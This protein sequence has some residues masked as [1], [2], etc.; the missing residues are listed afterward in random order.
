MLKSFVITVS[1][2]IDNSKDAKQVG[3]DNKMNKTK[4]TGLIILCLSIVLSSCSPSKTI[5]Q[6]TG[7]K[8]LE[9]TIEAQT[10]AKVDVD[11][12]DGEVTIK[13]EDGQ[14][15]Y[16]AGGSAVLPSNFPKELIITSDAKIIIASTSG[17]N[18]SVTY[19]TNS[20]QNE[21]FDKYISDLT[22]LGWTKE[23][24]FD[25]G[26]GKMLNFA[27]E[28]T[29]VTITIGENNTKDQSEKTAVNIILTT[30]EN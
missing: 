5:G 25:A 3:G 6:K 15:Q 13:S 22:G 16:S 27:K 14:T 8:I 4:A 18:S 30:E 10:G 24:E 29:K 11:A 1:I 19:I 28:N 12:Q 26:Q 21:V 7:E 20:E 17:T 2:W 9:K 23:M